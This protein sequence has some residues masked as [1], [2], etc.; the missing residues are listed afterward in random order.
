MHAA[1][2]V[3][4]AIR[5]L[6]QRREHVR[7]QRIDRQSFRVT[8]RRRSTTPLEIDAG[9]VDDDVQASDLV[10]LV[11]DRSCLDSAAE[12]TDDDPCRSR[13]QIGEYGRACRRARVE[14]HFV[15]FGHERARGGAA[16]SIGGA[17]DEDARHVTLLYRPASASRL[18]LTC[19]YTLNRVREGSRGYVTTMGID[20][21]KS[22][23]SRCTHVSIPD[24]VMP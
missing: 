21:P 14:N 17:R 19:V 1:A 8:L 12:I 5:T 3:D 10:D 4:Q 7:R 18:E 11:S 6:D 24:S 23:A 15:A 20:L 9:V 16:E 2:E 22:M 13:R